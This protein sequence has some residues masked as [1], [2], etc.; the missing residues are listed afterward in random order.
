MMETS[1]IYLRCPGCGDTTLVERRGPTHFCAAC[2]FDYDAFAKQPAAFEA[3]LVDRMRDGP[4]ALLG[5]IALHRWVSGQGAAAS[6]RTVRALAAAHAIPLPEPTSGDPVL[7]GAL[8][9]VALVVVGL[10]V[11]LGA[12]FV[13]G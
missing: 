2:G 12:L 13:A 7:R 6:T 8:V 3:Y 10:V 5:A 4:V 1:T 11:G 9:F